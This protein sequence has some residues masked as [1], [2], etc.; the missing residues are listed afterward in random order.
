MKIIVFLTAVLASALPS[1]AA[2][3]AAD[4]PPPNATDKEIEMGRKAS[5]EFEKDPKTKLLDDKKPENKALLEKLNAMATE[6]G[7]ASTRPGIKYNVKV[8]DD[9][10]L[11]A[12]TL[13]NGQIY[14]F[15]GLIDFTNS[16]DELAAVMAHEIGHNARLHALRGE[17][18][19]R[20]L[21]WV[22][23]AAMLGAIGAGRGGADIAAFSQYL[24]IGIMNGYGVEYEK[25]ADNAA[26]H[27]MVKT[28]YNPSALVTFMDRLGQEEKSHPNVELGIFRTH[29]PSEERAEATKAEL[30]KLGLPFAPR[31]VTGGRV[32]KVVEGDGKFTIARAE[33]KLFEL[34]FVADSKATV[35]KRADAAA[36]AVNEVMRQG[37]QLHEVGVDAVPGGARLVFRG[38]EIVRCLTDD[39]AL[40]KSTPQECAATWKANWGRLFWKEA[41]GGKT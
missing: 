6:L 41:L 11:N 25:E 33:V 20:K 5:A 10:D 40:Q 36:L 8:I 19:A 14:F 16:D 3:P 9:K 39:A 21:N 29:P 27:E 26:V 13:P 17:A 34:A 23:L 37:A 18:K 32:A 22:G 7:K 24:L 2:T 1:G 4:S 12:F 15:K 30:E 38:R 28:I 31:E 35:Q